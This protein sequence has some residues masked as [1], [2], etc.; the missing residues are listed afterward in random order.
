MSVETWLRSLGLEQYAAAFDA[1]DVTEDLLASLTADDLKEIGIASVGHRRRLLDAI[2]ELTRAAVRTPAADPATPDA[3][4][5]R[6]QVSVVFC[7]LEG[8]TALSTR[9]DPEDLSA[10]IQTYQARVNDVVK[11]YDGFI[12]RYLGDGVLIY[13]GWP[14]AREDD[15]ERAVR[16]ALDV[17]AA[18]S[19]LRVRDERLRVRIGIATGLVV[20]GE[21]I[22]AADSLQHTAIG[23]TPNRAARLQSVAVPNSVVIDAT[24]RQMIG[25]LFE[26]RDL[27]PHTLA[28]LAGPVPVWT[29]LGE[30][31]VLSRFEALH[32]SALPPM[33]GRGQELGI[34]MNCWNQARAGKG[35][36]VLI[37]GEPGIGKSRLVAA[38]EEETRGQSFI[39]LRYFSAAHR[40]DTPWAPFIGQIEH[41]AGFGRTDTAVAKIAR[42]REILVPG[43]PPDDVALLAMMLS[44]PAEGILPPLDLPARRRKERTIAA[45]MWQLT[46]MA[47]AGPLVVQA[48]DIHWS[49]PT[50]LEVLDRI[51]EILPGLPVLLMLTF[52]PEFVAPWGGRAGVTTITLN[53]LPPR[54]TGEIA[55]HLAAA[56]IPTALIERLVT[57]SDGI[58]LFIEELTR[59]VLEAGLA[60]DAPTIAKVPETLQA[61]ILARLDRLPAAKTAA[62]IGS[63]IGRSFSQDLA[64]AIADLPAA[65]LR[66]GLDQLV[67]AGLAFR[68]GASP[69]VSYQFKHAL[70]QDAAYQ[71]MVRPRRAA[72][73]AAIVAVLEDEA[74]DTATQVI[75]TGGLRG[76]AAL[77]AHHSDEAGL[78]D[79]AIRYFLTAGEEASGRGSLEEAHTLLLRGQTLAD[80]NPDL[81]GIL[82]WRT[83]YQLAIGEVLGARRF[84]ASPEAGAGLAK[85]VALARRIPADDPARDGL[86]ARTLWGY[87]V[88]RLYLGEFDAILDLSEEL[89]SLGRERNN[90]GIA[91]LGAITNGTVRVYQGAFVAARAIFHESLE[92]WRKNDR[93][94]TA[95]K[96]AA[97]LGMDPVSIL[98]GFRARQDAFLGYPDTAVADTRLAMARARD[99]GHARSYMVV[100]GMAFDTFWVVD[101]HDDLREA[102]AEWGRLAA[103]QGFQFY[104][105]RARYTNGWIKVRDG[106]ATAG[107]KLIESAM[108][109]LDAA[110][111]ILDVPQVAAL[112][113]D[114][115]VACGDPAGAV[116]AID[117]GLAIAGHTGGIW[118]NVALHALRAAIGHEGPER[119]EADHRRA[120]ATAQETSARG[121]ALRAANGYAGFLEAQGRTEEARAVLEPV[122]ASFTEGQNRPP[123]RA[124]AA[125]LARLPVLS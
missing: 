101:A 104:L 73:H 25:G 103:E 63:V 88:H 16:A 18:M 61:S 9:L 111:V 44:I 93:P 35:Q 36:A 42:L 125:L 110:G 45:L 112:L 85:A 96:V 32:E 47:K 79:K 67:E 64:E 114:A 81:P 120:L 68:R 37:T 70:V 50:S 98:L 40:R 121:W 27:G 106:D 116:A 34:L 92:T 49:D 39:K 76:D 5:E 102:A 20:I 74:N 19:T 80:E 26:L 77:L 43:T 97:A 113:A 82:A 71:S 31:G 72:L 117:Q 60:R 28:G 21:R 58:P 99:L 12:A 48:E 78:T 41:A 118:W 109:E 66:E 89:V 30:S 23:E 4:P 115:R 52:R 2:T 122:L 3:A 1:N 15:P 94:E 91:T 33:I 56:A 62:Q 59:A 95:R 87:F 51:I 29:V 65:Q 38:F 46:T 13:F 108:D 83:R 75:V 86:L 54:E 105:S 84:S 6:R 55:L 57:R 53:R 10:I 100:L 24:T 119:A 124:A 8:S 7:D 14:R 17:I 90:P 22:G 123:Q 11:R 107:R 69:D